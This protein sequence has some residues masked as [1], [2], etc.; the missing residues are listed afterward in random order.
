MSSER[1]W[2]RFFV[3]LAL[4]LN[5][6]FVYGDIDNPIH[7]DKIELFLAFVV[8]VVCTILKFGDRSYMGALLLA[9]SLVADVQLFA[10][11]ML[12]T[13]ATTVGSAQI[14]T[15]VSLSMGALVANLVSVVLVVIEAATLRR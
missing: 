1:V 12:W 11:I 6:G 14:V 10:A 9:T 4:T 8:S 2:F 5:V 7:H 13:F 3:L 15:I